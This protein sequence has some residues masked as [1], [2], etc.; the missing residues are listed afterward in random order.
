MTDAALTVTD[1]SA[2]LV[3]AAGLLAALCVVLAVLAWRR[4]ARLKAQTETLRRLES[5]I[6]TMSDGF[7]LWDEDSRL[8]LSNEVYR[9]MYEVSRP[10]LVP[11]ARFGDIIRWGAEAGQYPEAEGRIDEFVESVIAFHRSGSQTAER[12]LHDGRWIQITERKM[13]SGGTVGIRTDIT[14]LKLAL[15]ELAAANARA[16]AAAAEA[17]A[18]SQALRQRDEALDSSHALFEAALNNMSHGLTMIDGAGR[19]IVRNRQF[20]ELVGLDETMLAPGMTAE[21]LHQAMA[22]SGLLSEAAVAQIWSG[23][24]DLAEHGN[25]IAFVINT[26]AGRAIAVTQRPLDGGWVAIYEDITRR[27]VVERRVRFLALHDDLTKLPNRIHFRSRLEEFMQRSRLQ[28]G[29][30]ALLYLDL[31]RFKGVNDT[32]GHQTGDS[33][34]RAV[35]RRLRACVRPGDVIARLGGDEFAILQPLSDEDNRPEILGRNI[36]AAIDRPFDLLGHR[37]SIGASIGIAI[38]ADGRVADADRILRE[39]DLAL[40][41]AKTTGRG[42]C[43]VYEPVLEQTRRHRLALEAD[44]R[45]AIETGALSLRYQPIFELAHGRVSGF[46]ALARWYHP[47]RG[48]ISPAEFVPLAEQSG[49]IDELGAW[50]L[51]RACRDISGFPGSPKVAVNLSTQQLRSEA[52]VA[53]V[54]DALAQSGLAPERLELEITET[55]LLTEVLGTAS[56]LNKFRELG[57]HIVLDDFGTGYSSLSHLRSFPLSKIKID[58]SFVRDMATDKQS[59]AIV[60]STVELAA[61]LGML[62]TVEGVET[63]ELLDLARSMNCTEAQGYHLGRPVT[64]LEAVEMLD[65]RLDTARSRPFLR[66]V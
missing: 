66:S 22:R 38:V 48:W 54:A 6:E 39:A 42:T 30:F 49:L 21:E 27:R 34:L 36:V 20:C 17:N 56:L 33:L 61:K 9:S 58:Q 29:S 63:A 65:K 16:E 19:L 40:Y 52:I 12:L 46:E 26:L 10:V 37:I 60:S 1:A 53:I 15:A 43:L 13:A 24:R 32:Y 7:V 41:Q 50:V 8:V 47:E 18:R 59:S 2:A 28:G 23:H 25:P 64:I 4:G 44:L 14:P 51:R 57:T 3:G 31:D 5:A 62:T 35:V 55:A 45:Q 11:G